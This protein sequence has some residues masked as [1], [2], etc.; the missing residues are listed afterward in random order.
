MVKPRL[1]DENARSLMHCV[2]SNCKTALCARCDCAWH[3]NISC[4]EYQEKV[5][6]NEQGAEQAFSNL[7]EKEKWCRCPKCGIVVERTE[8]CNHMTHKGCPKAEKDNRTD[9]CYICA[10]P[11]EKTFEEGWRFS[12]IT[13]TKHFE[14]GVFEP[15]VNADKVNNNNNDNNLHLNLGV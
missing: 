2:N 8:G 3:N 11:L 12:A 13:H 5:N 7:M 10:E 14:N 15:C 1:E 4:A 6:L 9:F